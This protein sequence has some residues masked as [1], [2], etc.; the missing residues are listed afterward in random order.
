MSDPLDIL[1]TRLRTSPFAGVDPNSVP[2][3][4]KGNIEATGFVNVV[5]NADRGV[6]ID[7]DGI[8][9]RFGAL[10]L[11]DQ[12]GST[13]L[14]GGGFGPS[15]LA[16]IE[17]GGVYNSDFAVGTTNDIT[18]TTLVGTAS[19]EADYLASLS[20]DIPY[21]VVSVESGAG[22]LQRFADS[23][24]Q[25]GYALRWDGTENA[26]IFQDVPVTPGQ[27]VMPVLN[28][29]YTNSSSEFLLEVTGQW[30]ASDH[31]AIGS[32]FA[33]GVNYTNTQATYISLVQ[34]VL[35]DEV[36]T[37]A[38]YIRLSVRV[39][40]VSGSPTVYLNSVYMD[41]RGRRLSHF[42]L[43]DENNYAALIMRNASSNIVMYSYE[44]TD[45]TEQWLMF[46]NG[47]MRW[48]G[49][50]D[51]ERIGVG[52]IQFQSGSNAQLG[53]EGGN[54]SRSSLQIR[55][56]P[57]STHRLALYGDATLTGIEFGPGTGGRD[58]NLYRSAANILATDDNFLLE[59][60]HYLEFQE[61]AFP[62]A[63]G[64][65]RARLFVED[66]GAGKTRLMI[67]FSSGGNQQI[68]IQP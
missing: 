57:D 58:T 1:F 2:Q 50:I 45:V 27:F 13:V 22:S 39:N 53:V 20:D 24:A 35:P 55:T 9:I 38:R 7:K 60:G 12:F 54:G 49:D 16:Y 66:N 40:R 46:S 31:S 29:R 14:T 62:A 65:N 19:T 52:N 17:S 63:P 51:L 42:Y 21:W 44:G 4:G 32:E 56:N 10:T 68:A 26:E 30:R 36:P 43:G 25:G 3:E 34:A 47:T 37:N 48:G 28:L 11:I 33:W 5:E 23:N 67:R 6:V 64:A 41:A 15:W 61:M 18:A 59:G 8:T